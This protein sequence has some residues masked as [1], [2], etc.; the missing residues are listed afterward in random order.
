MKDRTRRIDIGQTVQ[1][2]HDDNHV[3]GII[4]NVSYGGVLLKTDLKLSLNDS[5]TLRHE[6]A[7]ELNGSVSRNTD[8]GFAVTFGEDENS[9]NFALN[10]ITSIMFNDFVPKEVEQTDD[11]EEQE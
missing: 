6:D 10:S 3:E 11:E 2:T 5:V 1:I 9:A 7:G 8:A 4:L